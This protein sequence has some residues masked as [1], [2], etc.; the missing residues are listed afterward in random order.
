[1]L[2][3]WLP[4]VVTTFIVLVSAGCRGFAS[5]R[6]SDAAPQPSLASSARI[7]GS[8][9]AKI[10]IDRDCSHLADAADEYVCLTNTDTAA[11]DMS[12]WVLRNVMGRSYN[13]PSGFTLAAGQTVKVH[14]GAGSNT[15]TDL[16]WA[17]SV[18]PAWEKSDKLTLHNNEDV[19]V[20]VS[21]PPPR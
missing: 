9:V 13:F 21:T 17:Y 3:R 11:A 2:R 15:A 20:F 5:S 7:T 12:Q 4:F 14:T 1:M 19:E 18:N 16:H 6:P 8:G 10:V